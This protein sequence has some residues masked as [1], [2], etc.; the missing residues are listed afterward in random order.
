MS[1]PELSSEPVELVVTEAQAGCR[2]DW[3]L[4]QQFPLYSRVL[5]RKAIN[6]AAA[7]ID[8]QRRKAA[9]KLRAGERI[10]IVLPDLPRSAPH[11][12]D[13]PLDI[14]YEDPWLAAIN[15]PAG[16]VV[17]PARGH[18][19]G[20]LSSALRFHFDQLSGTGGP[21]RPGIVH[22]LDRDTS[23][24]LLVA[25]DD[26]THMRLAGLFEQRTIEK[27][28]FT[29][30]VGV[31]DHDR[32]VIERPIGPHPH[33]REKMAVRRDHPSSRPAATYYEVVERFDGFTALKVL[34]KT[35]RTHQIRLHLS[36]IGCHVLCDKLYGGRSQITRAELLRQPPDDDVLL[37]RQAL[38]ARRLK[39]THPRTGEI[40]EPVA[41]IAP[42]IQRMLEVLRELRPRR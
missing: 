37:A 15:K 18:W 32:D 17:H 31:P 26:Q 11:P 41:P 1:G 9:H 14:V 20:T 6:A 39:L 3:F 21:T 25:K 7:R 16:M 38:H 42:D 29:I 2:F 40:L 13:I 10:T 34:P 8:G 22:R 27:E 19:S 28:Y 35:G 5:L 30:V 36:S 23:G 24:V 4:A 33:H 12:E